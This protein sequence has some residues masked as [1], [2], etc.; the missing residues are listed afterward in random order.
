MRAYRR[1]FLYLAAFAVVYPL[2]SGS[3]LLARRDHAIAEI[4]PFAPWTLFCFTP[5]DETDFGVRI[6]EVDGHTLD[7]ALFFEEQT[8]LSQANRITAY[9]AIQSL[10]QAASRGE[11]IERERRFFET[12]FLGSRNLEE[13]RQSHLRYELVRR[14]FDVLERCRSGKFRET[15]RVAEWV[16]VAGGPGA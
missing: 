13:Q 3:V 4:Y 12:N 6:L 14:R 2:I 7:S 9:A 8:E 10:G 5:N 1:S 15:T 16:Y 11:D